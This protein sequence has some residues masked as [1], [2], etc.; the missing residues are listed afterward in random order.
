[1]PTEDLVGIISIPLKLSTVNK[2]NFILLLD[3]LFFMKVFCHISVQMKNRTVLL[4]ECK[5]RTVQIFI[6]S[7]SIRAAPV[8]QIFVPVE[9]RM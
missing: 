6:R 9:Q 7:A 1:M 2:G 3:H 4:V 8:A 5:Q